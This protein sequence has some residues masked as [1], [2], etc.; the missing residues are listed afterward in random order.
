MSA[1]DVEV[2]SSL[3]VRPN[4]HDGWLIGLQLGPAAV[5]LSLVTLDREFFDIELTGLSHLRADTFAQGNIVCALRVVTGS[6][7]EEGDLRELMPA[8]HESAAEEY[9]DLYYEHLSRLV[10][11]IVAGRRLLFLLEPSYGCSLSAVAENF[12]LK[13]AEP[14]EFVDLREVGSR[15]APKVR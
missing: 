7:P 8:P 14:R 9:K 3:I 11:D 10:D 12:V 5:T 13:Q 1:I 2:R 4:V 6:P 15:D